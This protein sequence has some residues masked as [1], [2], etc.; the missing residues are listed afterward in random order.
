MA[1]PAPFYRQKNGQ[2]H[3]GHLRDLPSRLK[4]WQHRRVPFLLPWKVLRFGPCEYGNAV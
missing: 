2:H 3:A 1:V 4:A